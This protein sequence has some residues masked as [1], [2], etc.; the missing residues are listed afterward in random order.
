MYFSEDLKELTLPEATITVTDSSIEQVTQSLPV[1]IMEDVSEKV[2]SNPPLSV[3]QC[4][5]MSESSDSELD[6]LPV[7]E[8]RVS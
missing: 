2:I 4:S 6:E 1:D 3:S 7:I 5:S 8:D